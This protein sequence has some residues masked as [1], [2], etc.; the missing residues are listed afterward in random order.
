MVNGLR[1]RQAPARTSEVSGLLGLRFSKN[2]TAVGAD[3]VLFGY[4]YS[5]VR[6]LPE[7]LHGLL[8]TKVVGDQ[9]ATIPANTRAP[10]SK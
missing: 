10:K 5:A 6:T 4:W 1:S 2:S 8:P 7:S 3:S 9:Q